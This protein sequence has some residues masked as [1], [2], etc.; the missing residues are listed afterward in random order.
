MT[1][2]ICKDAP[3]THRHL[4]GSEG[5]LT[6]APMQHT[7]RWGVANVV[8]VNSRQWRFES[9]TGFPPENVTKPSAT[10]PIIEAARHLPDPEP[11]HDRRAR[12]KYDSAAFERELEVALASIHERVIEARRSSPPQPVLAPGILL[13]E[14]MARVCETLVL[15]KLF[16]AVEFDSWLEKVIDDVRVMLIH[17]NAAYG[18]SALNPLRVFSKASLSEQLLVRLDDKVSRLARGTEAG[19]DVASDMLGYLVLIEMAER[20]E[21]A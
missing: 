1:R 5:M 12:D 3:L 19:E 20:R 11:P 21:R 9:V 14:A 17:K 16:E 6:T 4:V 18:D 13:P 2:V 7:F 10:D 15:R 8:I